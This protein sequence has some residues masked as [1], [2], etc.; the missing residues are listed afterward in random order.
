MKR[1]LPASLLTVCLLAALLFGAQQGS[2]TPPLAHPKGFFGIGPQTGITSTDLRYM[3]AGGIESVRIPVSWSAIEPT[4]NGGYDWSGLDA[5]VTAT[6]RAGL[7]VLPFLYSTPR[8]LAKDWRR[9]PV[10]NA[11]ERSAWAAFLAAAVE[12]YGPGGDFWDQHAPGVPSYEPAISEPIPIRTWQIWNEVNFF[13]FAYPVSPARYAKLTMISGQAIK[14]AD[15]SATVLL[16]GLFGEPTAKGK[17]GMDADKFLEA[18][19]RTPGIKSRFD[20][21]SLHPYAANTE[22][23]EAMVEGMHE[24][25]LKNHDRPGFY[26]TEMGWGSQ[27]DYNQVAFEQG[28]R[29]QVKQLRAAYGYLLEN[30]RRLNLKGAYWFSWKDLPGSCNF[31]DSV[32]LFRAGAKF[33]PKPAWHA[34]VSITGGRARP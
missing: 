6:S 15:P 24:V 19:Y 23:L 28:I 32:G 20:A 30:Q 2:A 9:L 31:C 29:G 27:N 13:Y 11:K 16:S 14:S 3:R 26:I 17:R 22:D 8:W 10:D 34:F 18:L 21:F 7:R 4:A 5:T 25:T 33:H 1:L 12:R